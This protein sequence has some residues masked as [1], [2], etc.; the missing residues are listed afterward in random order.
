MKSEKIKADVY[1]KTAERLEVKP[2]ECIVFEDIPEGIA[3]AEKA[4]MFTVAVYDRASEKNSDYLRKKA[5]KYILGFEE[6][7]EE[8]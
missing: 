1:I 2:N 6:M 7:M 4:G 3:G 8:S 5:K